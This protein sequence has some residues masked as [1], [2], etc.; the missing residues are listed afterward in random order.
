MRIHALLAVGIIGVCPALWGQ[1]LSE[2]GLLPSVPSEPLAEGLEDPALLAAQYTWP[3][4]LQSPSPGGAMGTRVVVDPPPALVRIQVRVPADSPPGDDI[5]YVITVR[6][7]SSAEAHRVTVRNP[8]PEQVDVVKAEPTWHEPKPPGALTS[9]SPDARQ[10]AR[11]L[12]WHFGTLKPNESKT[13]ELWLRP[14]PD[15]KEVKNTAYVRYEHGQLTTTRIGKPALKVT[16][17]APRSTV[18]DE[19]YRVTIVVENTSRVPTANVRVTENVPSAAEVEPITPGARKDAKANQWQW[20]LGT[21]MPGERKVIEYRLTPRQ[22]TETL[23][24]THVNGDKSVLETAEART[25]VLVPGLAVK[26]D[27]PKGI[28]GPGESARY[29]ITVRNTGTLVSSNIRV[30]AT[31]P[32]DCKPNSMTVGGSLYRDSIVWTIPRLDPGEARSFRFALKAPTSGSRIVG[33]Q[34]VD[35]RGLKSQ[36]EL[37]TVF[38]GAATLVWETVPDPPSVSVGRQGTFTIRVRN[39]GGEPANNVTVEVE[40]PADVEVV[41]TTRDVK[42]VGRKLT[43]GP[44]SIAGNG[45]AVFTIT[46]RATRASAAWFRARLRAESLGDQPLTTEKMVEILGSGGPNI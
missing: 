11:E 17:Q 6:N 8:L 37:A 35:A 3:T 42:P 9:A 43:F 45:E 1:S 27:G 16:K 24:T 36:Q 18:R 21:L 32:A 46:Y 30:T 13:I 10:T 29:E 34:A 31:L 38:Q 28:V 22:V 7:T 20:Q 12:V 2:P 4:S 23:T 14:R 44:E 40:L 19:P 39:M 5:R 26:L 15:A 25:A 33:A 41:Q